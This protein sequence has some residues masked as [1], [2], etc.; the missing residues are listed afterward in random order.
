MASKPRAKQ[1]RSLVRIHAIRQWLLTHG[2][3]A[4][5]SGWR[6]LAQ[7]GSSLLTAFV[8]AVSLLLPALL[9]ALNSNLTQLL[10]EFRQDRQ[11]S[12]YLQDTLKET[13]GLQVSEDLLSRP[14]IAAVD[15]I[16]SAQGL[17]EFSAASGL[18][19]VLLQLPSNPLPATILV[20]PVSEEAALID[21]LATELG[22]HP[23]VALV[24]ID[25]LWRQRLQAISRLISVAGSGLGVIVVLGLFVIVGNT[26]KLA[27]ENRRMEIS[28]IKLVGGTD[29][30]IARP[31]LYSG[32]FYGSVGGLLA[33]V[34]QLIVLYLVNIPLRDLLKLYDS[35]FVLQGFDLSGAMLLILAGASIGW[36]AAL[37]ASLRHIWS[38]EP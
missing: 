28:V 2:R 1:D 27:I 30:Y 33:T 36:V 17:L 9:F 14:D 6:L 23:A 29:S 31:F 32:L 22:L 18:G 20:T 37:I 21:A 8:I 10:A 3:V 5:S 12:L 19:E 15:F 25:R 13:E 16:S 11:I 4:R 26:I 34:L 24:Q 35:A 38:L 7:P